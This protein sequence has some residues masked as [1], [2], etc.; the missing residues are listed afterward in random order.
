MSSSLVS[1]RDS[2]QRRFDLITK[3]KNKGDL[4]LETCNYVDVIASD[5]RLTPILQSI[6]ID[7]DCL[8]KN[9]NK[10]AESM[11]LRINEIAQ[12]IRESLP[13]PIDSKEIS[14]FFTNFDNFA[15]G[16]AWSSIGPT[17]VNLELILRKICWAIK[18][19]KTIKT[20]EIF[21]IKYDLIR[22]SFEDEEL[23]AKC[24]ESWDSIQIAKQTSA[25]GAWERLIR[26]YSAVNGTRR[27]CNDA[28]NQ[29]VLTGSAYVSDIN[30]MKKI[31]ANSSALKQYSLTFPQW[32]KDDPFNAELTLIDLERIHNVIL[33]RLNRT[34]LGLALLTKY[35]HRCEWYAPREITN[36]TSDVDEAQIE[37]NEKELTRR[38]CIFLHDNN[39]TPMSE[40]IFGKNIP[41]VLFQSKEEL[42]PIEVK[43]IRRNGKQRVLKG[44]N[45][46]VTYIRTISASEGF[47]I[48]FCKGDFTLQIPPTILTESYRINIVTINLTQVSPSKRQPDIWTITEKELLS[49]TFTEK[50]GTLIKH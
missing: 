21:T 27:E 25:W 40:V 48:I 3:L 18:D 7:R 29:N 22:F 28:L 35:Q 50:E 36:L 14:A 30:E 42:F 9:H 6:L 38:L 4:Y 31:I 24:H 1:I 33:D 34:S 10:L 11:T 39:V 20:D 5:S 37:T 44:F 26:I 43:V 2:L 23:F 45:Q 32:G 17:W 49:T 8:F 16:K 19:S 12:K 13:N 15:N 46:I 47:Y 41:D